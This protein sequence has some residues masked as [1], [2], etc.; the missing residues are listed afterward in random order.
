MKKA[1]IAIVLA[2]T[3]ATFIAGYFGMVNADEDYAY[4]FVYFEGNEELRADGTRPIEEAVF[5][6]LSRDGYNYTALNENKPILTSNSGTGGVRDPFIFKTEEGDYV[7]LATDMHARYGW[8]SNYSIITWRSKDL[9]HWEDETIIPLAGFYPILDEATAAWAPQ[10]I[11]DD[12]RGEYLIYF[13][14]D[15]PYSLYRN[16]P[17]QAYKCIYAFYTKD[18]VTPTTDPRIFFEIL[19]EDIIDG[20]IVKDGDTYRLFYKTSAN[21]GIMMVSSKSLTYGYDDTKE[22]STI[23]CEGSNAYKLIDQEK[24]IVMADLHWGGWW[25]VNYVLYETTDF[26]SFAPLHMTGDYSLSFT[27]RHG[28]VITI[29]RAEYMAL[30]KEF[31]GGKHI[32]RNL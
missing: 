20:D 14:A 17:D 29:S 24:W 15:K 7:M 1:F 13:S 9:V 4:L 5:Y 2:F 16:T 32:K 25:G 21:Q 22:V 27:P 31:N 3:L 10:A 18:F 28:Y 11:Y 8:Q 19:G 23:M 12:E 6:A 30:I 26:E